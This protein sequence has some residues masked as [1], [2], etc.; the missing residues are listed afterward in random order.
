M[1][2][3]LNY[4]IIFFAFLGQLYQKK[5]IIIAMAKR[6]ISNQYI[7]S[8]LGFV[9]TFLQP[10]ITITV[11]WAIFSVVFKVK[12]ANNIPFVTWLIA[13]I[14]SWSLFSEI[15][16]SSSNIIITYAH[17]IKKTVFNSEILPIVRILSSLITHLIFLFLL[18]TLMIILNVPITIYYFQFLYYL[19]CIIILSIGLSWIVSSLNVFIRDIAKITGVLLQI[20]FWIT[21][22]FWD[23]SRVPGPYQIFMKANPMFYVVQGYRESFFYQVPFWHHPSQT[24][25]FWC[26]TM[27]CFIGGAL[28]FKNL[29]PQFTD[30]L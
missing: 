26:F 8:I 3:I 22:I 25:Y 14:A 13:G 5:R 28:I 9:W 10:L 30:V 6:E 12:P 1:N 19:F 2:T 4:I 7:G 11:F 29:K 15:V 17:L 20:G 24:I 16:N 23:M 18:T 27:V 21:G